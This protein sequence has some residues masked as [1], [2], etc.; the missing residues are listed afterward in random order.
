MSIITYEKTTLNNQSM[1]TQPWHKQ[2]WPWFLIFLPASAVVA[3]I[4]TVLIAM[5]EP[6]GLVADDYYKQGLAINRTL[7]K[8]QMAKQL[9]LSAQLSLTND[10]VTLQLD[11]NLPLP[12]KLLIHF[13]HPTKANRDKSWVLNKQN[14]NYRASIT[15]VE[16]TSWHIRVEPE[17]GQWRLNGRFN[18]TQSSSL[19]LIAGSL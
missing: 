2:F 15:P 1:D 17:Q 19:Q 5:D 3:G 9:N 16:D 13:I 10:L 8:E 7:A 4:A 18:P 12:E 14:N 11:G 6:D